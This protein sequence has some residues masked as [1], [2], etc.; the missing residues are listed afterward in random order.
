[1]TS[2]FYL[3]RYIYLNDNV[4]ELRHT[5]STFSEM[6]EPR[7]RVG[8]KIVSN[9]WTLGKGALCIMTIVVNYD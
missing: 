1:V 3:N 6:D 2:F 7:P 9:L 4:T 8:G 5:Q